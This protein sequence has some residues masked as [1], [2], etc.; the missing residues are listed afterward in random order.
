MEEHGADGVVD[1][2]EDAFGLAILWGGIRAGEAE[3]SAMTGEESGG[4]V[5]NELGAIICLE[6]FG[7]GAKLC[8]S[9]CNEL[10][11]VAMHLRFLAK[12]KSPA[13]MGKIIE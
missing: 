10:N 9:V 7:C 4:G 13:V 8:L 6:G 3:C 12:R 1:C 5:V 2:A 11:N